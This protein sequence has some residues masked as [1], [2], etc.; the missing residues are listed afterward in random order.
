MT[1]AYT[2]PPPSPPVDACRVRMTFAGLPAAMLKPGMSR[3]ITPKKNTEAT[4]KLDDV[5]TA[6][7]EHLVPTGYEHVVTELNVSKPD[8]GG[9]D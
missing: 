7:L 3:V 4:S 8:G 6:V 2:F 9:D 1:A 5:D